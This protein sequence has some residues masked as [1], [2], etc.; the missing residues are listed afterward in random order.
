MSKQENRTPEEILAQRIGFSVY[1]THTNEAGEEVRVPMFPTHV[2]E[3]M[4][5]DP[6][7]TRLIDRTGIVIMGAGFAGLAYYGVEG[8]AKVVNSDQ[9]TDSLMSFVVAGVI[10]A[11]GSRIQS[12]A[13]ERREAATLMN[14]INDGV[15]VFE[16]HRA[17][18]PQP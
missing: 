4:I 5:P 6:Q 8:I 13:D 14:H 2:P 17:R 1:H 7:R 9:H 3:E 10:M 12:I 18:N 16:A 11:V 15:I